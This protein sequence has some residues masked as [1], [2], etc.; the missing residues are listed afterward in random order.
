M[1]GA[2]MM[3]GIQPGPQVMN[4][5]PQ[6][7]WSLIAS[8][9]IGNLMLLVINLPLI[10]MWIS[11]LKIPYRL[12]FPTI[13]LFCCIGTYGIA[14]S[15]FN[16]WLMLAFGAI[17]YFFIKVKVEP[18]PLLLGLVLGPQLEENFRR[19][20]LLSDGDFT[21]FISSPISAALLAV[22]AAMLVAMLLPSVTHKRNE[23]L[24]E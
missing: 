12:L 14:N 6:L 23:A 24:A 13:V 4:D 11:M 8:M 9:W 2:L 21:V 1:I 3:H 17:G 22:V 16:V 18:A 10:G 19:A 15:M 5:Q 20:M 7:V